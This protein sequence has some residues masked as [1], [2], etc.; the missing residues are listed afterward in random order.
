MMQELRQTLRPEFLNRIDEIVIFHPLGREELARIVD[1]QLGHLRRRLA[2]K[3]IELGVTDAAK[4]VLAREGYD[5]T[6]GAR[7]LKRT[8]Q[9]LVQDP[10]ALKLL[11]GE[12]SE[13]DTV[14]V[15]AEGD[16]IVFHR[17]V[18]AEVV[19]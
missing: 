14:T 9:R 2:D 13:G 8:I 15:D 7:P 11:E 19:G 5:P 10:L 12:F 3:R 16:Q 1:I 6:F 18:T 17:A 4:Q